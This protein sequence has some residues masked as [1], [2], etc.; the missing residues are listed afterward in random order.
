MVRP[1]VAR[2]AFVRFRLP[3]GLRVLLAPQPE[4]PSASVW[5]WYRVGS[6]NEWPGVTGASHW[7][8]HMLF[9]GSPRYGKG[10][11]DRA[12]VSVGGELNAFT[13]TDFTAYF[14]TVPREHL[15]VPLDI[16]SDR[17]TRALITD[18][19]VGRERTVIHSE[20][21]G[22]ENWPEFRVEEELY[23]LAFR[24]HP[25]RWDALGRRSDIESL[26]PAQ[27]REYYQRFYGPRNAVLVVSGGFDPRPVAR[28]IRR[29]FSR[30]PAAGDDVAVPDV[31]PEARGERR[32]ELSGPG[33]TPY[34]QI[35]WRAPA[36]D[37]PATP[38]TL[39]LDTILGGEAR[40]F[41]PSSGWG[42]AG[43]HPSARLYR[44][45]VDPGLAVRATSE[46][47]PRVYPGLFTI[48]AQ[49][50]RGVSLDRLEEA[51]HR[52][53][54]RFART[55][56]TT[57]EMEDVRAKIRHGAALAYEGATRTGFRL[58][59]F[60]VLRSPEFEDE[61]Y[62]AL[63]AVRPREIAERARATFRPEARV[64]VRYTPTDEVPDG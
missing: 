4:S 54:T 56:P 60:S 34:L 45:L 27:L 64:V 18:E 51:I 19:E 29:R 61:L 30:L 57:T 42:R 31:E 12:V 40:L 6:K 32:A 47:R 50:A 46:W 41:S 7:V 55:G 38:A 14:T 13:D 28:D 44:A 24:V 9:E 8:E 17:M 3:N 49:A 59:Y 37:D 36:L 20:R 2:P 35:G 11:I 52:L 22:N 1:G 16:E 26:T 21:E 43:E 23:Q 63:L 48:Q 58:G 39:L 62:R 33:T 5:V 25:Y 53:L 15:D 10:A